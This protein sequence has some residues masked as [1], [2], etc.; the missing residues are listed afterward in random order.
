MARAS[1]F[2]M[3]GVV[4]AVVAA[5]TTAREENPTPSPLVHSASVTLPGD[6]TSLTAINGSSTVAAGLADGQVAVWRGRDSVPVEILKPHT[7]RVLAVAS[8]ADGRE[9]WSVAVDG[10]IA[11]SP[12]APGTPSASTRIDFGPTPPRTVAFSADGSMLVAG[13]EFGE[14]HV[15]DTASGA[16]RQQLRG[17]RTE[18]QAL[19]VRSGSGVVASASA[20]ADLRV[21]DVSAG[22]EIAF[23][24]GNLSLFAVGF[25]PRDGTLAAGGVDRRLTLRDATTFTTIGELAL[26]APRMVASLSWSP[27]GR[28]IAVGDLDDET[29][30]KGGIQVVDAATRT[31]IA[32]LETGGVP[33][34]GLAFATDAE[35]IGII[36][37]DLRAWSLAALRSAKRH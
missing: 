25:S 27:D 8:T 13:G 31:V 6:I 7:T 20:E 26:P 14:I 24:D 2:V 30:S 18:L 17:H 9:V 35:I 10:S 36:G 33:S 15:F 32:N 16:L 28:L 21:W 23:V 29:L 37:R 11:R 34:A 5:C 19:A 22:R 1:T 4:T 12:V 3:F